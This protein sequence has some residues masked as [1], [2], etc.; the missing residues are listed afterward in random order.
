MLAHTAAHDSLFAGIGL[1]NAQY[2]NQ[3]NM[4]NIFIL[5]FSLYNGLSI[6]NYFEAYEEAEDHGAVNTSNQEFNGALTITITA[7]CVRCK[8]VHS[9]AQGILSR[10][11]RGLSRVPVQRGSL[12]H[13]CRKA[14]ARQCARRRHALHICDMP[15]SFSGREG[16]GTRRLKRCGTASDSSS[17]AVSHAMPQGQ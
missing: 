15:V 8:L 3:A 17:A 14:Q 11:R 12:L 6:S 16:S 10:L 5:G 13:L 4:R 2:T 1:S 9:A 7:A